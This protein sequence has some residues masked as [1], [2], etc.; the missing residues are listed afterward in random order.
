MELLMTIIILLVLLLIT[1][2]LSGFISSLPI[3]LI[4]IVVGVIFS[5]LV[6]DFSIEIESEWFLLLFIA[7]LLY[8]DGAHFP[9]NQLWEL[10]LPIL[11][12]SVI[13]VLLTTILGGWFV[14]WM[15]PSIPLAAFLSVHH[16]I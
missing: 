9:R 11:G 13:L 4:Q 3:A 7:P 1:N 16:R 15:I 12:N 10:R 6:K 2:L 14:H 5:L 8:Y